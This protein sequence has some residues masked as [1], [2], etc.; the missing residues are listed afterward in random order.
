[1]KDK[2]D[3]FKRLALSLN[4]WLQANGNPHQQIIITFDGAEV[5]EGI[6]SVPFEVKD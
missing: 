4:E 3:E 1:M 5:V 2:Y 6:M